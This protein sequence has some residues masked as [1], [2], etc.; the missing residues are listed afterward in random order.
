MKEVLGTGVVVCPVNKPDSESIRVA[1]N[2]VR[3]CSS[4]IP[5]DEFWS[6]KKKVHVMPM[7]KKSTP[8]L[9]VEQPLKVW[10]G[11]LRSKKLSEDVL[12]KSGDM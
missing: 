5:T 1:W 2:R 10:E 11:R 3:P 6:G 4:S 7:R 8:K 12:P 9:T